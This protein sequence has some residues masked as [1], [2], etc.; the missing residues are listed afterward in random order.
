MCSL[1]YTSV[2]AVI[3]NNTHTHTHKKKN[4]NNLIQAEVRCWP[5]QAYNTRLPDDPNA[6]TR[7]TWICFLVC[8]WKECV[9]I[10]KVLPLGLRSNQVFS[11]Q[12]QTPYISYI[13]Y[14]YN[15]WSRAQIETFFG[16]CE[17]KETGTEFY[18]V[19]LL[20]KVDI[21]LL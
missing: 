2:D 6:S 3:K 17:S 16:W 21:L 9:Y 15:N 18:S 1:S 20:S 4:N 5:S 12:L 13:H 7:Y 19:N 11:L 14:T 10:D 8:E